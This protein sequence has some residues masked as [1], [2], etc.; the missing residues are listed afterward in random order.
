[1]V[2]ATALPEVTQLNR[3]SK[4]LH[5]VRKRGSDTTNAN[6]R[7]KDSGSTLAGIRSLVPELR[8]RYSV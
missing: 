4:S 7:P 1:M 2:L 6:S 3:R 8:R 5:D